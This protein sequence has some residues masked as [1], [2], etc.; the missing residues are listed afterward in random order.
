[1]F[2]DLRNAPNIRV[3]DDA[4]PAESMFAYRYLRDHLLSFFQKDIPLSTTKQILRDALRGI[5][6]LHARGIVHTDIKANNIL[7]EWKEKDKNDGIEVEQVQVSDIEDA[8]YV[9]DDCVVKGRQVGNWMW[10]SPEAHAS[11][12]VHKPSDMFSFGLVVSPPFVT[13]RPFILKLDS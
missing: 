2:D 3:C 4:I 11:A 8:A 9:P 6:A 5:A 1:M 7:V 13:R 10:R 12:D